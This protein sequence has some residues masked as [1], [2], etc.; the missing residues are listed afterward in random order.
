LIVD[1]HVTSWLVTTIATTLQH[2]GTAKMS[3]R[4]YQLQGESSSDSSRPRSSS[5][6]R[7]SSSSHRLQPETQAYN[8]TRSSTSSDSSSSSCSSSSSGYYDSSYLQSVESQQPRVET[9]RCSRCAKCVETIVSG[10]SGSGS[11]N[12][13]RRVSTDDASASGMVRFGHNL[14]Y[15]DRC[16]KMVGYKWRVYSLRFITEN[17]VEVWVLR[18][19]RVGDLQPFHYHTQVEQWELFFDDIS[20]IRYNTISPPLQLMQLPPSPYHFVLSANIDNSDTNQQFHDTHNHTQMHE[21]PG[22]KYL[23]QISR[24]P[25][26]AYHLGPQTRHILTVQLPYASLTASNPL[27]DRHTFY[28]TPQ[29]LAG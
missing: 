6:H 20:R 4:F 22:T 3:T 16:A 18:I 9:L 10:R 24:W 19:R 29:P 25:Q 1:I 11:G 23:M 26:I 17:W 8:Y 5:H 7:P 12:S 2:Y 21:F 28:N 13:L 14:Y 15:C 27:T